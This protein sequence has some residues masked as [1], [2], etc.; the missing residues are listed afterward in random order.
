MTEVAHSKAVNF[1][2]QEDAEA[3]RLMKEWNLDSSVHSAD[4]SVDDENEADDECLGYDD[5]LEKFRREVNPGDQELDHI[6]LGTCDLDAAVEEFEKLTGMKPVMVV[7]VKGVGTKSARIAF[8]DCSFLEIIGPDPKQ[9]QMPL[10]KDLSELPAGKLVPLHYAVRDSEAR[11]NKSWESVGLDCDRVTMLAV[12]RNETWK[13]EMSILGNHTEGG[14]VP[15]FVDWG[16]MHHASGRL[17]ILGRLDSVT[18]QSA[19]DSPVHEL[20]SEIDGVKVT[21]GESLLEFSFTSP[22]GKHTFSTAA[23]LGITFPGK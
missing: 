18:V 5:Y 4:V 22:K 11:A 23:P 12:D 10:A 13:W 3:R 2:D 6:V 16:D 7:S 17:P 15:Y 9:K 19:S 21:E 20:L 14:L 1:E 8:E